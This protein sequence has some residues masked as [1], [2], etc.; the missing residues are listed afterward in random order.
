VGVVGLCFIGRVA[1]GAVEIWSP[2]G[3]SAAFVE[4]GRS[5]EVEVR[6]SAGLVPAGFAAEIANEL[7]AWACTVTSASFARIN[8]GTE[9]G[10]QLVVAVPSDAPPELLDLRISHPSGGEGSSPRSAQVV[11]ALEDT[12]YIIQLADQHLAEQS[13]TTANG[14]SATGGSFEGMRWAAA[15]INLINP[16]FVLFTGDNVQVYLAGGVFTNVAYGQSLI[17]DFKAELADFKVATLVT[18][19]NRDV[20][21]PAAAGSAE[22]SSFYD[23]T[24]G[25]RTFARRLGSFYVMAAEYTYPT[26]LAWARADLAAA[27][28]DA[29]ITYALVGQ[30][31]SDLNTVPSTSAPSDLMLVGHLH[32]TGTVQTTPFRVL[33]T[34]TAQNYHRMGFF[35]F[36]R[37]PGGWSCPQ[38]TTHADGVNVLPAFGDWGAPTV[39]ATWQRA[40]DGTEQANSVTITNQLPLRFRHGRLRFLMAEGSYGVSG[41]SLEA[42]YAYNGGANT[43]VLVRTDI[44]SGGSVAVS[45]ARTGLLDGG[46]PPPASDGGLEGGSA[47]DAGPPGAVDAAGEAGP[48]GAVDAASE[49]GPQGTVDAASEAGPQGTVDAGPDTASEAGPEAGSGELDGGLPGTPDGGAVTSADGPTGDAPARD[50]IVS[51]ACGCSSATAATPDRAIGLL[52]F[53]FRRRRRGVAAAVRLRSSHALIESAG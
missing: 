23:A 17:R 4:P 32:D 18:T 51:N 5:L 6:A 1:S 50:A 44:P 39:A 42:Q 34:A 12:F 7:S 20:G 30:H 29:S 35:E 41:A 38:A 21:F 53:F 31:Y 8:H 45:I 33:R 48:Q 2:R 19:G 16:R 13:A 47:N 46:S 3:H 15:T 22:M 25:E 49:A 52:A 26:H 24:I 10:W 11:A 36:Q 28:Q 9:D 14:C 40:N 27:I 37:T 43:A